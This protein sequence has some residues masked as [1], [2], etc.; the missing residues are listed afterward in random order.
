MDNLAID[1]H[2][3]LT[4][5]NARRALTVACRRVGWRADEPKLIRLGSNA[6]FRVDTETIARVAPSHEAMANAKKQIAVSR[7]LEA[8]EYPAT[9]AIPP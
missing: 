8:I 3:V 5:A 9:R 7:W 2:S 1:P 6:V 4:E